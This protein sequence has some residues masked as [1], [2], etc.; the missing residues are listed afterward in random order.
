MEDDYREDQKQQQEE[1]QQLSVEL[2]NSFNNIFFGSGNDE[3]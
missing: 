3:I 2:E 1:E